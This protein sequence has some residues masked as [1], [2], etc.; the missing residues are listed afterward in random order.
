MFK[1][2]FTINDVIFSLIQGL[3]ISISNQVTIDD[4]CLDTIRTT[5]T[6]TVVLDISSRDI[7]LKPCKFEIAPNTCTG[8]TK[9]TD[10]STAK[11]KLDAQI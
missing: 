3:F 8:I 4:M 5:I 2:I 11:I 10:I 6:F 7:H 9:Q 1:N